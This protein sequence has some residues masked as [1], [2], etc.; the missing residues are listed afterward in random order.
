V[1]S[2]EPYR[3]ATATRH[4]NREYQ[5][6]HEAHGEPDTSNF[7]LCI[8]AIDWGWSIEETAQKLTEQSSKAS[9]NG[10]RYALT[11]ARNAAAVERRGHPVKSAPHPYKPESF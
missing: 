1:P 11:T 3:S 5:L 10:E 2:Q 7:I 8:T 6:P 9:E 4:Q